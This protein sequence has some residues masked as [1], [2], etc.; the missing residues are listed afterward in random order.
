MS[1]TIR[2]HRAI[3]VLRARTVGDL[4]MCRSPPRLSEPLFEPLH[5]VHTIGGF[6]LHHVAIAVMDGHDMLDYWFDRPVREATLGA[7]V[8]IWLVPL[9]LWLLFIGVH[10]NSYTAGTLS[11]SPANDHSEVRQNRIVDKTMGKA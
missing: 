5:D 6:H 2:D 7:D 9:R 8:E 10:G 1:G 11:Y 3:G 4:T